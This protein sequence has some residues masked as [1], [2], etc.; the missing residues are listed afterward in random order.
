MKNCPVL[1]LLAACALVAASAP[2]FAQTGIPALDNAIKKLERLAPSA[3]AQGPAAE[4][5]TKQPT[6]QAPE[7]PT[8]TAPESRAK[9]DLDLVGVRLGMPLAEAQAALKNRNPNYEI[10]VLNI[11]ITS[12]VAMRFPGGLQAQH[13]RKKGP[14]MV[15]LGEAVLVFASAPPSAPTVLGVA[16]QEVFIGEEPNTDQ[17][18]EALTEKFGKPSYNSGG[19]SEFYWIFDGEFNSCVSAMGRGYVVDIMLAAP[20]IG[21]PS[22]AGRWYSS[23]DAIANLYPALAPETDAAS[24]KLA[25][26]CGRVVHVSF[27]R[28][29]PNGSL[30]GGY[31]IFL[32]DFTSVHN[33][34]AA[35]RQQ[36]TQAQK[37]KDQA[38]IQQSQ[39]RKKPTF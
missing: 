17:F 4:A 25:A 26:S 27:R 14:A 7:Q 22:I 33:S 16:R 18:V 36:L 8:A 30:V 38:V 32:V 39:E 15:E 23:I 24:A 20:F 19:G 28:T 37:A 5:P 11:K 3:P 10:K 21:V 31:V 12:P 6:Q 2:T 29:G 13:I 9:R 34:M 35:T 1:L